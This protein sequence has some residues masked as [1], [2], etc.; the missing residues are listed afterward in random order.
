MYIYKWIL[1]QKG[2]TTSELDHLGLE[3]KKVVVAKIC[4]AHTKNEEQADVKNEL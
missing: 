2:R 3:L 1:N 4:E